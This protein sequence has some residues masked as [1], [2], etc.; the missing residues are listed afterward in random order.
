MRWSGAHRSAIG[1]AARAAL[2]GSPF[3]ASPANLWELVLKSRKR[4]AL[5]LIRSAGGRNTSPRP[6]VPRCQPY[7]AYPQTGGLTRTTQG[8]LRPI[9]V[10]QA[11]A[12]GYTL[13]TKDAMLAR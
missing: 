2:D 12:E 9:L 5:L 10:A 3:T 7:P 8:P 1:A 6:A 13:A 4:G 11:L